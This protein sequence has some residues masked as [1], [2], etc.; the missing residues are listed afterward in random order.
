MLEEGESS[1]DANDKNGRGIDGGASSV[2]AASSTHAND[3][4]KRKQKQP[5]MDSPHFKVAL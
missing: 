5:K 4:F 3:S 1:P 2:G